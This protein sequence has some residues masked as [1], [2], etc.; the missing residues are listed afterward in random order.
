MSELQVNTV[1]PFSGDVVTA[2]CDL[3]LDTSD[4]ASGNL[5]V[6]G[7]AT[8]TGALT[9]GSVAST[10]GVAAGGAIT[11]ASTISCSSTATLTDASMSGD[12]NIGSGKF[13]V[14]ASDGDTEIA[15]TLD[16]TSAATVGSLSC[17]GE[18][19]FDSLLV[20]GA[21]VG[22]SAI[23]GAWYG[24]VTVQCVDDGS[25]G[26]TWTFTGAT[27]T[28]SYGG[29]TGTLSSGSLLVSG[30]DQS[31]TNYIPLVVGPTVEI[32]ALAATTLTLTPAGVIAANSDTST[33]FSDTVHMG[34]LILDL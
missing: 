6:P 33:T 4:G 2:K 28:R 21:A 29:V 34:L 22:T 3:T 10:G 17:T 9:A 5:I 31:D 26:T 32:S 11:G 1:A 27:E 23:V 15:G 7:T 18:G 20:G 30:I 19:S 14:A 25:G 8:I 24:T 13:T 16:V 12:L